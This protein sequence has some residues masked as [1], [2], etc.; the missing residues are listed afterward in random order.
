M[1]PLGESSEQKQ[2]ISSDEADHVTWTPSSAAAIA[3][4]L[5]AS[6]QL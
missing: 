2:S 4:A 1:F 6:A 3:G 5:T